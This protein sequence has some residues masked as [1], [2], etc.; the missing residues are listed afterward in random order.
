[1]DGFNIGQSERI[2]KCD[3][4]GDFTDRGFTIGKNTRWMGCPECSQ[5]LKMQ[6][7]KEEAEQAAIKRQQEIESRLNRSGIPLRYRNKDF[8][9]YIADTEPKQKALSVAVEFVENIAHH[10]TSGTVVVF[11]GKPGTGKS[12]LAIAIAQALM[13]RGT[14][15]Y[16]SA[17][18]AIRM[19]RDTWRKGSEQT[20]TEVINML[21]SVNLLILDEIGVQYGTDAEQITLFDIIDKR[22]REMMPMILLTNQDTVG[23]RK[24][25]GDRSFDR[26]R[27]GGI[28][29]QFDWPS[30]RGQA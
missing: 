27:E 10:S 3:I 9:T 14:V 16:L 12:H 11:S 18:D 30:H 22:Y 13:M 23:M 7:E 28:W 24:F 20:E 17:I 1:M 6:R 8:S 21:S 15:M 29:V 19:V 2:G 26:L 25:L 5:V 4:H